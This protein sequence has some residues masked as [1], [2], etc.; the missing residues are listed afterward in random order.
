M[1]LYAQHGAQAGEKVSEGLSRSVLDGVIF[2]PRDI[3]LSNLRT[4][5]TSI[6]DGQPLADRLFDPQYY[7]CMIAG[8]DQSRVGYLPE[9]YTAYFGARRRQDLFKEAKVRSD[10]DDVLHF[11]AGLPVT[12]LIAPNILIPRSFDSRETAIA[13]EFLS[14][15]DD[16]IAALGDQR[17]V[18]AT[19]AIA[20]DALLDRT[21]L[22][23]F[24]TE[25]TGLNL[26]HTAGF[27]V[28]V[29]A[30]SNEA[31]TEI[32]HS[33]IVASWMFIN[34]VF[35]INGFSVVN[36]YSDVLSPFLLAAGGDAGA[37]GWWS[38][39]R[40]FSLGRFSP[41]QSGGRLPT[42]RYLSLALLNRITFSEL[43]ILR[44]LAPVILNGLPS[45]SLYPEI[46]GSEPKRNQEV[47][48]SWDTI[49]SMMVDCCMGDTSHC[50][51][52][53]LDR[54]RQAEVNYGIIEPLLPLETKSNAD[55]LPSLREGIR[56]FEELAELRAPSE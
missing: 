11:Q 35:K 23:E 17:P 31:R 2:S 47:L 40:S 39:L 9:D 37:T 54:V 48:Q 15:L 46:D 21:Q 41:S 16:R 36:G 45:D 4:Q 33:D 7:T 13:I 25:I 49:K 42:P 19:L 51:A 27:Y 5:L 28:L 12:H 44:T 50:L 3:S 34:H 32:F 43:N 10:I 22:T 52:A 14:N 24:L 20:R 18:L 30:N 8:A 26:R 29:A 53:V 56:L 55:H 6:K 1:K 38:N